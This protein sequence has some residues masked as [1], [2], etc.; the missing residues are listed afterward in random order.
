MNATT[1]SKTQP[2]KGIR[3]ITANHRLNPIRLKIRATGTSV[4]A[5]MRRISKCHTEIVGSIGFSSFN[6]KPSFASFKNVM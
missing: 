4:A 1:H 3:Q 5:V 6:Y 2:A